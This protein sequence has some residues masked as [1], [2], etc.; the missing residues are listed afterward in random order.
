MTSSH[1]FK[2]DLNKIHNIVQNVMNL[3]SKELILFS[4]R[5]FFAQDT[6]YRYVADHYGYPKVVDVTDLPL[7]S[8]IVDDSTTRLCIQEAFK[9]EADFFP[10]LIVRS[11]SFNSIPISFNK[12]MGSVQWGEMIFQDGYGNIK[13][14][15]EPKYFIFAGAWEGSINID[16]LARD[17]RSR[18]DLVDLV[19]IHFVDLAFA[20]LVKEG[21]VVL[22]VSTAGPSE[23]DDRNSKLFKDTVTLRVRNEWRRHL[24][25]ANVVDIISTAIEFGQVPEGIPAAN[26]TIHTEQTLMEVLAEL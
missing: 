3:H 25:V 26:L 19:S 2:S 22:N 21:L 20:E 16:V 15:K 7:D 14:F 6:V 8:G 12:E 5:D 13:T 9:M 17:M 10:A 11:G 1:F 23:T 24:P 18:D 4:L